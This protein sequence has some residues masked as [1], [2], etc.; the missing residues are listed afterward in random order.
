VPPEDAPAIVLAVSQLLDAP[1][2]RARLGRGARALSALF[3]WDR[4]AARTLEF[5]RVV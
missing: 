4:I 3:T 1:D 2:L 5:L